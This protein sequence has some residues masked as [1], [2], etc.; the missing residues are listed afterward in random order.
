MPRSLHLPFIRATA[1]LHFG[2]FLGYTFRRNVVPSWVRIQGPVSKKKWGFDILHY[3]FYWV[4]VYPWYNATITPT[5]HRQEVMTLWRRVVL[6]HT[7]R[8]IF[9]KSSDFC[10]GYKTVL[11]LCENN[12]C[13]ALMSYPWLL[14]AAF[15]SLVGSLEASIILRMLLFS[16]LCYL[17]STI[18]LRGLKLRNYWQWKMVGFWKEEVILF[19]N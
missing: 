11:T 9:L 6:F 4:K 5:E 19:L 16:W 1:Y 2:L 13:V 3:C 10:S 7:M 17:C 14:F 8:H 15:D 18:V 12:T